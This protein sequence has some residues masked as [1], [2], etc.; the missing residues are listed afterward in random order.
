MAFTYTGEQVDLG[1]G[2]GWLNRPA[3]NSIRRIDRQ[4]G[5]ALQITEA[6]RT[7]VQQNEHYQ[8]YL[9]YGSPIALNPDAP[10]VHQKGGAIDSNEAQRIVAVLED[11]GWRRTV[12]RWVNGKWTLVEPWHFEYFEHLDNHRNEGVDDM[13]TID[14]TEENYQVLGRMLQR[15]IKFDIREGGFGPDWKLGATLWEKIAAADDS[16]EVAKLG[17]SV[18]G[19]IAKVN[20]TLAGLA[21]PDL[22]I[23]VSQLAS[24]LRDGLAPEIVAALGKALTNG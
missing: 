20:V 15:A 9:R 10:S 6:G 23:D 19:E 2:R 4:I 8:R 24:E 12:Y 11:H 13:G 3:A 7:W 18:G 17:A 22:D 1:F 16:A 21:T 14:N 5:H